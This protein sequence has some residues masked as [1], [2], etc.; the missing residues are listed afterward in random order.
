MAS[1]FPPLPRSRNA[2]KH[3]V[4]PTALHTPCYSQT[5]GFRPGRTYAAPTALSLPR[6]G[7]GARIPLHWTAQFAQRFFRPISG[8]EQKIQYS[9]GGDGV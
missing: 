4:A 6:M 3:C 1:F 5:Q 7:L 8:T 9:A 2:T